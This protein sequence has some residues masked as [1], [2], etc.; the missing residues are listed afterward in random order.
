MILKAWELLPLLQKTVNTSFGPLQLAQLAKLSTQIDRE[1]I[2]SLVIDGEFVT[3]MVTTDGADVLV[4]NRATVQGAIYQ[5]FA[6]AAAAPLPTATVGEVAAVPE[7]TPVPTIAPADIRVEVLNGSGRAG[8]AQATAD[9]IKQ[10][11]FTNTSFD[12][13]DRT[14][15]AE[16]RLLAQPGREPVAAALATALGMGN[17]QV[18]PLPS[19]ASGPEIRLVLGRNF[20][21]PG[22]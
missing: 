4:P 19:S 20:Q 5:A 3:P 17:P 21:P 12:N 6:R 16:T 13:A 2:T 15:Y 18:Q 10:R 11:G 8:L 14:D 7:P 22:R 1:R 9:L